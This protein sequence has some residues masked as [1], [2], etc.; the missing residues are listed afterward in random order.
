RHRQPGLHA[1][2]GEVAARGGRG[3]LGIIMS[4]LRCGAL[5]DRCQVGVAEARA[6][7]KGAPEVVFAQSWS[8]QPGFVDALADRARAALGDIPAERRRWTPLIFSAHSI[9][10]AMADASPY[11]DDFA[12]LARAVAERLDHPRRS[13]AYQS[14]SGRP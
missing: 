3:V 2:L 4:S 14:R 12:A 6:R 7:A 13:L 5:W 8:T 11:V 9:P 1:A 10:V